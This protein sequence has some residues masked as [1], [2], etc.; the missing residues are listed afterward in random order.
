VKPRT[1]R[2]GAWAMGVDM[3]TERIGKTRDY[4]GRGDGAS[5]TGRVL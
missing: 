4:P 3:A 1:V 5:G 2:P